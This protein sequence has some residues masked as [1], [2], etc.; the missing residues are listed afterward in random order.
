MSQSRA[1]A[2][3]RRFSAAGT[4]AAPRCLTAAQEVAL[5]H[6]LRAG[7]AVERVREKL[8]AAASDAEWAFACGLPSATALHAVLSQAQSARSLLLS[9]NIGLV[10]TVAYRFKNSLGNVRFDD[11]IVYGLVGLRAA[12]ERFDPE[13][14]YRFS[15]FAYA[16]VEAAQRRAI[17]NG[18]SSLRIPVWIQEV[19]AK[20]AHAQVALAAD[21]VLQPTDEQLAAAA[22]APLGHVHAV[23]TA[24]S[25]KEASWEVI[26]EWQDS[27]GGAGLPDADSDAAPVA[28]P[29]TDADPFVTSAVQHWEEQLQSNT[30]DM[31]RGA[32]GL[33]G[34]APKSIRELA[35]RHGM[36][37]RDVTKLV[38]AGLRTM[39]TT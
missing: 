4:A 36:K 24:F 13:R 30:C 17:Q 16:S 2:R 15:T 20:L 8:S 1:A 9:R 34:G 23:A 25:R 10:K 5:S 14:G 27:T 21:G 26:S 37:Q 3:S 32:Y 39:R 12:V 28:Q 19:Q 11:L 22:N 18:R 33:D 29:Y 35:E 38:S 31:L 6:Q 7:L